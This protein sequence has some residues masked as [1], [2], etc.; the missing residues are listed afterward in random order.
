MFH[1]KFPFPSIFFFTN[2][3]IW[4]NTKDVTELKLAPLLK[5]KNAGTVQI[6]RNRSEQVKLVK[7]SEYHAIDKGTVPEYVGSAV[8]ITRQVTWGGMGIMLRTGLMA[9]NQDM[10]VW[11]WEREN[12]VL[13]EKD[14]RDREACDF[15]LRKE[16]VLCTWLSDDL[17]VDSN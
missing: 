11:E 3:T 5:I 1:K 9:E 4:R 14:L 13:E 10:I 6:M 17:F 7:D 8:M 12:G 15:W 2:S 16:I